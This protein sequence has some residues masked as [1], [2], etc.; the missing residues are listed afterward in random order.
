M[1][2]QSL[3]PTGRIPS[4]ILRLWGF[5]SVG[6]AGRRG[7]KITERCQYLFMLIQKNLKY[8]PFLSLRCQRSTN[9]TNSPWKD[10]CHLFIKF[11]SPIIYVF[12]KKESS[13]KKSYRIFFATSLSRTFLFLKIIH[14][15][16]WLL[17]FSFGLLEHFE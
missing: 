15:C 10:C 12:S 14:V 16:S 11:I 17:D 8:W 4:I 7:N 13:L 5:L 9:V 6:D 2:N 1:I 3:H